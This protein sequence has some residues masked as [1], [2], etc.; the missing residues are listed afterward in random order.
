MKVIKKYNKVFTSYVIGRFSKKVGDKYQYFPV[1]SWQRDIT[2][3]K[4]FG[5]NG[6]EW[7]ISDY[8]NPI[9]NNFFLSQIKKELK[10]KH[11]KISSI[12]LDLIM[13]EPLHKINQFNLHW[14]IEKIKL[15]Q[16]KIKINRIN[17]PIEERARFRNKS[18]K[19]IA[20]K[21]LNY[22]LRKL[23]KNSKIS[24]ETDINPRKLKDFFKSKYITNLGLLLDIGNTRANGYRIED[25]FNFFRNKIYGFHI[26]YRSKNHG[27][28]KV[29]PLKFKE[30]N[31]MKENIKSLKNLQDITFQTYRSHDNFILDMKN[32][33]QNYNRIISE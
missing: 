28:S 11:I 8:S 1:D 33:I 21:R 5:F 24:I 14:L 17:I 31:I 9:F 6:I 20:I 3:A 2:L 18:E 15:V 32:S 12:A 23:G 22:I 27:N 4:K 10:N 7:I 25:Y 30:L 13:D 19:K 29:I 16:S 26:K